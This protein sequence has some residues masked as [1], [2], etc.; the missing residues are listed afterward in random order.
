MLLAPVSDAVPMRALADISA[1]IIDSDNGDAFDACRELR[2]LSDVPILMIGGANRD[3]VH[4]IAALT[5]GADDF[6]T[7]PVSDREIDARLRAIRRRARS[8]GACTLTCRTHESGGTADGGPVTIEQSG[9]SIDPTT[10]TVSRNGDPV[11]LTATE[12]GLL[13]ALAARRGVPQSRDS[14]LRQAWGHDYLG[15]SRI[16]DN[17]VQRL[18]SKIDTPKWHHV[19]SVRGFGYVL[20]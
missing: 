15:R 1:V 13:L 5:V 9:L 16:V 11:L 10:R 17:A 4:T 20:R 7:R 8:T 3:E 18:R 6:V 19:H 2:R 14:L 12:I